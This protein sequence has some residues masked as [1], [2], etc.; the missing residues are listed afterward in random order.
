MGCSGEEEKRDRELIG[1]GTATPTS[2]RYSLELS[3]L[4]QTDVSREYML[5]LPRQPKIDPKSSA[6]LSSSDEWIEPLAVLVFTL[7]L[8]ADASMFAINPIFQDAPIPLVHALSDRLVDKTF[9]DGEVILQDGEV[10]QTGKSFVYFIVKGEVEIWKEGNFIMLLQQGE[11]FGELAAL[12]KLPFRQATAK[13]KGAVACRADMGAANAD[14]DAALSRTLDGASLKALVPNAGP[15]NCRGKWTL[16]LEQALDRI[17]AGDKTLDPHVVHQTEEF[18]TIHDGYPKA[19]VHLLVLPRARVAALEKLTREH[20]PM[21]MRLSS[22]VAWLLQQVEGRP[23]VP[24]VGWIH[25]VHSVPSLKQ[26]HVHVMTL[27][28]NSPCMKNAKHFSSFLPP[29]LVSLDSVI[30]ALQ[31]GV[32]ADRSLKKLEED[33]KKRSLCC[34]RCGADF[35]RGF[36]Q[37]KRHLSACA[38]S[39]EPFW[40]SPRTSELED[41]NGGGKLWLK[42]VES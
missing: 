18:V 41:K 5:M 1:F 11:K 8:A 29:F 42:D 16:V 14:A 24:G 19:A 38:T 33:M 34:H 13:A 12:R 3:S 10:F 30:R 26:L 36:A 32:F 6:P 2:R 7:V 22:Y 40:P 4:P 27:D 25:G 15:L 37:L 9:K 31:D 35:G 28:L 21:L 20:L 23:G 39:P 17:E